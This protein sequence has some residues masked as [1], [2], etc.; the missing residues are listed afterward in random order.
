MNLIVIITVNNRP[1]I[2]QYKS[3]KAKIKTYD[4]GAETFP[5]NNLELRP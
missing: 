1:V 4:D 5:I 2:A 3:G